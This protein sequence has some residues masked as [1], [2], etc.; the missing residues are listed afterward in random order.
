MDNLE[1]WDIIMFREGHKNEWQP[2]RIESETQTGS[3]NIR[4]PNGTVCG[5][6]PEDIY[7][8]EEQNYQKEPKII[9]NT[10]YM[11]ESQEIIKSNW[12][13]IAIAII[14][15]IVTVLYFRWQSTSFQIEQSTIDQKIQEISKKEL[16]KWNEYKIQKSARDKQR[17]FKKIEQESVSRVKATN[18][19][20]WKIKKEIMELIK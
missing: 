14:I 10:K 17:E 8:I 12:F 7:K 20:I 11:N 16:S 18:D 13:K 4:M 9:H 19:E 1:I 6:Y 5:A 2:G 3:F 15:V